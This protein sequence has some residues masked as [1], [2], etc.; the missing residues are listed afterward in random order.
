MPAH[1]PSKATSR[2][3]SA[4]TR[5]IVESSVWPIAFEM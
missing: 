2:G 5:R 1:S 4:R 3:A